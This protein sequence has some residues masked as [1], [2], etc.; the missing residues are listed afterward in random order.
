MTSNTKFAA[1][2]WLALLGS[3]CGDS[4]ARHTSGAPADQVPDAA[5]CAFVEDG[6]CDEPVACPLGSDPV[7]CQEACAQS[8]GVLLTAACAFYESDAQDARPVRR[9]GPSSGGEGGLRGHLTG[10]LMVRSGADAGRQVQRHFRAFVPDHY[11]PSTPTP[12]VF[13]LPGHRVAVDPLMDYTQLAVTADLND[14]IVVF[15]EQEFRGDL[16]WAWWTDW[17]WA[18]RPDAAEHPDLIFLAGLVDHFA[19][20]YNIDTSRVVVTGHSRGAAM[21]LI[22]AL[23]RPDLFSGAVVQSGFTEF[24]YDAR[25]RARQG[26]PVPLVFVHGVEDPDVCIDCTPG[27]RCAAANRTCGQIYGSDALVDLL[28]SRGWDEDTLFYHRLSGVAHRWQPQLNQSTWDFLRAR[29]SGDEDQPIDASPL[30][31]PTRAVSEV[32]TARAPSVSADEMVALDAAT[33][34]MGVPVEAPS[35]YGDAWFVD[36][37]PIHEVS[38][39]AFSMDRREVTAAQYAQFLTFAGGEPHFH[40]DMPIV[41]TRAG[42]VPAP[43]QGERAVHQVS[44]RDADA[45][46]RWAGKRLPTEAQWEYAA[47]G[48]DGRRFPWP[49]GGVNCQ[50]AAAFTNGAFCADGP[51]APGLRVEG[52]TPE[53]LEGMAGNVAEWVADR[54]GAYGAVAQRDPQGPPSGPYRVIRGGSFLHSGAWLRNHARWAASQEARGDGV[55]FRCAWDESLEDEVGPAERGALAALDEPPQETP[56]RPWVDAQAHGERLAGGL[57]TP[58]AAVTHEGGWAV[59]E[60]GADR[61]SHVLADGTREVLFEVDAPVGLA[62]DGQRFAVA[63]SMG[64]LLV[65]R[66]GELVTLAEQEEGIREVVAD[67]QEI[68]WVASGALKRG[69]WEGGRVEELGA[70]HSDHALLLTPEALFMSSGQEGGAAGVFRWDRDEERLDEIF[71]ERLLSGLRPAGM[72]LSGGAL[73]V[74]IVLRGWPYAGLICTLDPAGEAGQEPSCFSYSPPRAA[75]LAISGETVVWRSRRSVNAAQ[76][77]EAFRILG[78]WHNPSALIEGPDPEA[79]YWLDR[80]NGSLWTARP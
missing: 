74:S 11:D 70:G 54:Y 72:A 14:F 67:G 45:Y 48:V 50:R 34:D 6:V 5:A 23:E 61:V 25:I 13:M 15:A 69:E 76:P 44:W 38:L 51:E 57:V 1:L 4:N 62:T 27:G 33:F 52:D 77:G 2:V 28:K 66:D 36:Q 47:A 75:Q 58:V 18:Q 39:S 3:A 19:A 35:P 21:A 71:G 60:T 12:L 79:V 59:A 32:K 46:C 49:E 56:R 16:R 43:G 9:A 80:D 20:R 78:A 10:H 65:H 31:W 73:Y 24:G 40:P 63:T 68:F 41:R 42:Y 37:R 30:V 8:P 29:P 53:G 7:D 55:G 64:Q 22:A 26:S 17:P